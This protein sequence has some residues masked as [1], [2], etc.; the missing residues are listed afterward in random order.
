MFSLQGEYE[1]FVRWWKS[2]L[3]VCGNHIKMLM[4]I[5][6][7]VIYLD[8]MKFLFGTYTSIKPR[9]ERKVKLLVD[10]LW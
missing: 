7:S 8:Y 4:Y 9:R 1:D 10:F 5:K 2:K 6:T 3:A